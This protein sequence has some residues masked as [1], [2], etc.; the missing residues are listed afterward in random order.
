VGEVT[1]VHVFTSGDEGELFLN[2]KSLGRKKKGQFEYRLRWDDVVY[3]QGTLKVVVY[4]NGKQWATDEVK[5]AGPVA[6]L[7]LQP[8]RDS[9]LADGKD[10]SFVTLTVADKAGL[11]SPRADNQIHFEVEGPGEIVATDNGDASSFE[12]FPSH[13]RKAFNGLC[14]VIVRGKAGQAGKIKITATADGLKTATASIK[15]TASG[16]IARK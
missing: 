3:Q 10:L 4:K 12:A 16:E 7:Q 6:K 13:D 14:L 5:T 1:P 15:T 11:M 8:D 9:I 2:G